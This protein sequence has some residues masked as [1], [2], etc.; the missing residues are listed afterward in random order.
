MDIEKK[1]KRI[2]QILEEEACEICE[3]ECGDRYSTMT[4]LDAYIDYDRL[5]GVAEKIIRVFQEEEG[6]EKKNDN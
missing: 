3:C 2:E 4:Q 6:E 1:R 5:K